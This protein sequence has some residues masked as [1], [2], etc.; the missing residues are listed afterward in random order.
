[1]GKGSLN[2]N[3]LYPYIQHCNKYA[4]Y[5]M[6]TTYRYAHNYA[7]TNI[8]VRIYNYVYTCYTHMH[9]YTYMYHAMQNNYAE[10]SRPEELCSC[11]CHHGRTNASRGSQTRICMAGK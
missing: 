4:L 9:M 3:Q 5:I 1:M 8:H 6:M 10:L 7:N 2:L 11:V